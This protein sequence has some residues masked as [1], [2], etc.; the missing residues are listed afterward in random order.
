MIDL[1][2]DTLMQLIDHPDKGD[3]YINSWQVNIP[4]LQAGQYKLQDFAIYIDL[5][6]TNEPYNR[7]KKMLKIFNDN[8]CKY[9]EYIEHIK[10]FDELEKCNANNKI[11]AL[12]SIE[13]GG[14]LEGNL[15]RLDEV[16]QDG[17]RLITI[18]WNY[19][20]GL[21]YP[22]GKEHEGKGLTKLGKDFVMKMED[23]GIIV[24]SSHLNDA[25][26]K[27]LLEICTKPFVAS[28]SC[29]RALHMHYRN[30]PDKLIR[31]I[32]EKGG[33]VGL[34]FSKYF[35]GKANYS[36]VV[37]MVNH[38]KHIYQKGGIESIAIGTDFDGTNLDMEI[39]NPGEM[40]K[41]KEALSLSGFNQD[42]IYKIT[43][44]NAKRII[45]EIL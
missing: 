10:N 7:Y 19:P 44:G 23:L 2:C 28:H 16:Y 45:K 21:S 4:Y 13:E 41:L 11:G 26:T 43:E 27:E 9:N 15:K 12:L 24:D 22:Q 18:S 8:M 40:Y 34:A 39:A 32:G 30:L 20:N 35:L 5:A 29:A 38:I 33:I 31:G 14:I 42:E 1:H 25:G 3:L 17:V 37:D 36:R 6:K